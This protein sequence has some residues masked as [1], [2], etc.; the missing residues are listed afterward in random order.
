MRSTAL[1]AQWSGSEETEQ[2]CPCCQGPTRVIKTVPRSGVTL[3]HGS[4]RTR[5]TVRVCL[6]ACKKQ[7]SLVMQHS[8]T[9]V[10]PLLPGAPSA[11]MSWFTSG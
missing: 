8:A 3:Q 5:E 4:F 10:G 1:R 6:S 9:L 2:D 11:T 7:G